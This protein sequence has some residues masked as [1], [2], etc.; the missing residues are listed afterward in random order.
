MLTACCKTLTV[1]ESWT[2]L[3]IVVMI[4]RGGHGSKV[5]CRKRA[6]GRAILLVGQGDHR[7]EN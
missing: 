7:F 1:N 4:R 3:V 5:S 2:A 6:H